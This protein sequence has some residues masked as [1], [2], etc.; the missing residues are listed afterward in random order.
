MGWPLETH[1]K[2]SHPRDPGIT[3]SLYNPAHPHREASY[4]RSRSLPYPGR[5]SSKVMN[6]LTQVT[7]FLHVPACCGVVLW[8][9]VN[10]DLP[11][12]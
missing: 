9:G 8:G 6:E 2:L 7:I 4:E 5:R 12:F 11:H 3:A 1:T 10:D